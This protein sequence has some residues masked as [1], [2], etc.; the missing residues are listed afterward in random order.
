VTFLPLYATGNACDNVATQLDV[1]RAS[2]IDRPSRAGAEPV[3]SLAKQL[4]TIL[5]DSAAFFVVGLI[6]DWARDTDVSALQFGLAG[7]LAYAI[8]Q[9]PRTALRQ[10]RGR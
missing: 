8:P 1:I 6:V 5:A 7:E 10:C 9:L 3:V 2:G 4:I